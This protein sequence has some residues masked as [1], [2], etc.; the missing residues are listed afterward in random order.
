MFE[1]FNSLK[2]INV[3]YHIHSTYTD[4]KN[5]ISEIIE[6]AEVIG[7]KRIAI[8]DH[9]RET[10]SYFESCIAEIESLR[11]KTQVEIL[12][13]FEARIKNFSGDIDVDKRLYSKVDIKIAS[14]HRF[15]IGDR[16]FS[17]SSFEKEA[18]Q[19]LELDISLAALND[20]KKQFNV[21]GHPGGM[22]MRYF[23][24]FPLNYFER[25]I[26][27]C[28]ENEVAFEINSEY[29]KLIYPQLKPMLKKYNPLISIGSD[30]HQKIDMGNC[31]K[32][33]GGDLNE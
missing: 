26:K 22:S 12:S 25:I 11:K 5:S 21:L 4:G 29:H 14:V 31:M 1:R 30:A 9:I 15:S 20:Q 10:S 32:L 19:G 27:A 6:Q 16:L 24:E 8:T 13:G 3:D 2:L 17:P 23:K 7:L 28:A 33:I 18:A